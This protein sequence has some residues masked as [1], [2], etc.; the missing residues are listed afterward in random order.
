MVS[1]DLLFPFCWV[2]DMVR[3]G[4]LNGRTGIFP[5]NYV[6]MKN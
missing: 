4:T 1:L 6:E 2:T 5:S 3:T